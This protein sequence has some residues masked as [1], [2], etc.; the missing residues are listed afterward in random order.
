MGLA[1]ER[2]ASSGRN[3][4]P[5]PCLRH[6]AWRLRQ[7]IRREPDLVQRRLS[8]AW[9]CHLDVASGFGQRRGLK[10]PCRSTIFH[11][12]CVRCPKSYGMAQARGCRE[13]RT[14]IQDHLQE[15]ADG[16]HT[17]NPDFPSLLRILTPAL[18]A[19]LP[20]PSPAAGIQCPMTGTSIHPFSTSSRRRWMGDLGYR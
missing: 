18:L 2:R 5:S 6:R 7:A 20:R 17:R 19:A 4:L 9:R 15:P 1:S 8:P 13:F 14:L 12:G 3:Q 16:C 10:R 11:R